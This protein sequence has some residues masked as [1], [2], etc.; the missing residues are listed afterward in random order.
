MSEDS[1]PDAA[2][3]EA[4]PPPK[5]GDLEQEMVEKLGQARITIGK[6]LRKVIIG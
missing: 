4:S 1:S 2:E 5:S 3:P 6:E